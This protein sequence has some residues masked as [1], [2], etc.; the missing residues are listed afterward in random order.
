MFLRNSPSVGSSEDSLVGVGAMHRGWRGT[1]GRVSGATR[2][3][4]RVSESGQRT[5]GGTSVS[6]NIFE[7]RRNYA[8]H[9][10]GRGGG[11]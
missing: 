8:Q 5:G 3:Q 6:K 10:V 11:G 9:G 1:A 4:R 7:W 2:R